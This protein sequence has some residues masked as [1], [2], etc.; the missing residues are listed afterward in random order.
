MDLFSL[1][2]IRT[3]S[4][5]TIAERSNLDQIFSR[6]YGRDSGLK[7]RTSFDI[8]GS[9]NIL[10]QNVLNIVYAQMFMEERDAAEDKDDLDFCAL[11]A[12]LL[13]KNLRKSP[14][15]CER[16][17]WEIYVTCL[18]KEGEFSK[19]YHMRYESF[20]KLVQ[21]LS[22]A[23]LVDVNQSKCTL[24][25]KTPHFEM[26]NGD[27]YLL[28]KWVPDPHFAKLLLFG[29][30]V[31]SLLL[32]PHSACSS[33]RKWTVWGS[34]PILH[35]EWG[36][37][38]W[39]YVLVCASNFGRSLGKCSMGIYPHSGAFQFGVVCPFCLYAVKGM[40]PFALLQN[41]EKPPFS[42]TAVWGIPHSSSW[43]SLE[44]KSN[45]F[46]FT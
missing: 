12:C 39:G 3:N 25:N 17:N 26:Q 42:N 37:A 29:E 27:L 15:F 6:C 5:N 20:C 28:A 40:S 8:L 43:N 9:K 38:V 13:A 22:P 4:C 7:I 11:S 14:I 36:Y 44:N 32:F 45:L 10:P 18:I 46:S 1:M 31:V 30:L 2:I 24:G 41:G 19:M 35:A 23:L 34:F 16:L 21:L 33:G